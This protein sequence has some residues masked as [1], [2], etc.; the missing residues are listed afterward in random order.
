M[1][2][3]P[4]PIPSTP[5]HTPGRAVVTGA[6]AG[7][8]RA[9]AHQLAARGHD[10]VLVACDEERLAEEAAALTSRYGVPVEVLACA[11]TDR[12]QLARVEARVADLEHPVDLLVNNAGFGL[13]RRF[14]DNDVEAEQR[15]LDV[16]VPAV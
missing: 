5:P 2:I 1:D 13:K 11:L 12:A 9:F 3:T 15:M 8:R 4:T 7:I 16:L 14:A 6:T 10:L